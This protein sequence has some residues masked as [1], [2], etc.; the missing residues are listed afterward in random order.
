MAKL[1]C[2]SCG[3]KKDPLV[4]HIFKEGDSY[5][6]ECYQ[7]YSGSKELEKVFLEGCKAFRQGADN[8]W[9]KMGL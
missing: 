6:S 5:K 2:P 4:F 1:R 9:A 3:K 8:I 7:C